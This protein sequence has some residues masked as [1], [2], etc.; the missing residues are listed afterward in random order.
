MRG[1]CSVSQREA[2]WLSTSSSTISSHCSGE[3]TPFSVFFCWKAENAFCALQQHQK[4]SSRLIVP[5]ARG[6]GIQQTWKDLFRK[7]YALRLYQYLYVWIGAFTVLMPLENS[8][9]IFLNFCAPDK[10]CMKE[11]QYL[12]RCR[13]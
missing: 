12:E 13:N 4:C 9:M 1:K 11:Q 5:P 6:Y 7:Q 2:V 3:L 10:N 8:E